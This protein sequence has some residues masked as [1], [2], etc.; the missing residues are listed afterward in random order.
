MVTKTSLFSSPL[1]FP[2][3]SAVVFV[4]LWLSYALFRR[5]QHSAYIQK[6]HPA[7]VLL[8]TISATPVVVNFLLNGFFAVYRLDNA[9]AY[10]IEMCIQYL[11]V[12]LLL[13]THILRAVLILNDYYVH[14]AL[15]QQSAGGVVSS[16]DVP[17]LSCFEQHLFTLFRA[18]APAARH[19]EAASFSGALISD[20]TLWKLSLG[21]FL[22]W[23][24]MLMAAFALL[25]DLSGFHKRNNDLM[26]RWLPLYIFVGLFLLVTPFLLLATRKVDDSY[27][28]RREFMRG[29]VC[30]YV[31]FALYLVSSFW[32]PAVLALERHGLEGDVFLLLLSLGCNAMLVLTP[33][34]Y[35]FYY[36]HQ[37]R[38]TLANLSIS[39][40]TLVLLDRDVWAEFKTFLAKDFCMENGLFVEQLMALHQS[41]AYQLL[42]GDSAFSLSTFRASD[43]S[44]STNNSSLA[45]ILAASSAQR[46]HWSFGVGGG[47]ASTAE[48]QAKVN[49]IY[50]LFVDPGS[51]Y[52]LN[53][54]YVLRSRITREVAKGVLAVV[55]LDE[56]LSEGLSIRALECWVLLSNRRV[57]GWR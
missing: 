41:P 3:L 14:S 13:L 23:A 27:S 28:M 12:P 45:E 43:T 54:S 51:P 47:P 25:G 56:A 46:F 26:L 20:S 37:R 5:Q 4:W 19:K 18:R 6:R 11:F 34:V 30:C 21:V 29:V 8:Q 55:V 17:G 40:F 36:E 22:F 10:Y 31:C 42:R 24:A 9:P 35:S 48:L 38:M 33:A 53:L 15:L 49:D 57:M 44:V 32:R 52:E 7:L 50:A 1:A 2:A 39:Q 16:N